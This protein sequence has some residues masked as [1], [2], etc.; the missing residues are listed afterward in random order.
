MDKKLFPL[1]IQHFFYIYKSVDD[2]F[3]CLPGIGG[4]GAGGVVVK[5]GDGGGGGV[6]IGGGVITDEDSVVDPSI[7][8]I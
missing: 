1:N 8:I 6:I 5:R 7:Q 2:Q 3:Q 4:E